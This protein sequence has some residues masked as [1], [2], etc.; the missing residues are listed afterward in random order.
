[1]ATAKQTYTIEVW[2][3]SAPLTPA[4]LYGATAYSRDDQGCFV[5]RVK[6]ETHIFAPGT[7]KR[8]VVIDEPQGEG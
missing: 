7:W 3:E 8:I 4:P 1:M 2:G 6:G 5:V